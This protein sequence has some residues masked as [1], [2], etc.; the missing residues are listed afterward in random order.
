MTSLLERITPLPWGYGTDDQGY[1]MLRTKDIAH[2]VIWGDVE[3]TCETCHANLEY[4]VLAA[5]ALPECLKVLE[6]FVVGID[7]DVHPMFAG[8]R[9]TPE[10][11]KLMKRARSLLAKLQE[12]LK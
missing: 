5:N 1:L 4:A 3:S 9:F 6:A 11:L 8:S 10:E 2:D 7:D 12:Q